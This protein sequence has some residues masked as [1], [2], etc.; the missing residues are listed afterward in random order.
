VSPKDLR[1]IA[2]GAVLV[3]CAWLSLRVIPGLFLRARALET[4]AESHAQ[5]LA[6][7]ARQ[8]RRA[9]VLSDSLEY[10]ETVVES[11]PRI[12]LAGADP[13]TARIDLMRRFRDL[14][15]DIPHTFTQFDTHA[16]DAIAGPLALTAMTATLETDSPGLLEVIAAL[17][18]DPVMKIEHLEVVD[19]HDEAS[20]W[21][22]LNV[23]VSVSGWFRVLEE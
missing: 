2:L 7:S 19:R 1:A 4:D 9:Q 15:A 23:R 13:Q 18:S 11:L 17:E 5:Q 10:Y 21:Q 14:V 12:L 8:A 6:I 16:V 22:D 3:F 20:P